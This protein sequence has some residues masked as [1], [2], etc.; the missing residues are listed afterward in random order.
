MSLNEIQEVRAHQSPGWA[1]A[2]ALFIELALCL[3]ACA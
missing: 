1:E 2:A 3:G